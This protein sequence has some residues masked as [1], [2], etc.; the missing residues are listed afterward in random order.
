MHRDK[1]ATY[2]YDFRE[3]LGVNTEKVPFQMP[4][5]RVYVTT[6]SDFKEYQKIL[7]K[8]GRDKNVLVCIDPDDVIALPN[9]PEYVTF[10]DGEKFEDIFGKYK[11]AGISVAVMNGMSN[12]LG[13]HM[14]GMRALCTFY[15]RLIDLIPKEKVRVDLHQLNPARIH[16][17]NS[18]W[19]AVARHVFSMP[20]PLELFLAYDVY[21]DFGGLLMLEDFNDTPMMD[22]YL[23]GLSLDPTS[24][25]D[26]KKVPLYAPAVE[27]DKEIE[28]LMKRVRKRANGRPVLLFHPT[29]TTLVR[30][31]PTE[32]SHKILKEIIEASEYF[33]VSATDTNG[34][35]HER[36]MP[37]HRFSADVDYFASIVSKVDACLSVDTLTY[38]LAAAFG[39]PTMV[40]FTGIPPETRIKYYPYVDG[41]NLESEDGRLYKQHKVDVVS[42]E[43]DE[44]TQKQKRDLHEYAGKLWEKVDLTEV[45]K[46][47]D[48]MREKKRSA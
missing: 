9:F 30:T 44:Q 32:F 39:V 29:A 47:L 28:M 10:R 43:D 22:F 24:V 15:E 45:L 41:I 3:A 2:T 17:I 25:D 23:R 48:I 33:V 42:D 35:K 34:F 16:H 19:Q 6:P 13:D 5:D 12:A 4:T 1:I 31:M 38:H 46:R 36:F 14:I 26:S 8:E 21:F 18:Q 11:E 27:A 7:G 37:L 40:L 20:T